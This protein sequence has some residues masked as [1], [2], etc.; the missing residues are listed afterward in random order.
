M[1]TGCLIFPL[2]C[3]LSPASSADISHHNL[4]A[5]IFMTNYQMLNEAIS[6]AAP[7]KV[8]NIELRDVDYKTSLEVGADASASAVFGVH[9]KV[10]C[11]LKPSMKLHF[12]FFRPSCST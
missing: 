5:V 9:E 8:D 1:V 12:F 11:M 10:Y 7:V 2:R 4:G 3:V 6:R